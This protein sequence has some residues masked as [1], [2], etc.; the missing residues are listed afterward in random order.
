MQWGIKMDGKSLASIGFTRSS[1][2]I[3]E[4]CRLAYEAA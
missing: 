1:V 2:I 3:G 4:L